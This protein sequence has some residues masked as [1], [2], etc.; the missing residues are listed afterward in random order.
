MHDQPEPRALVD[1]VARFLKQEIAPA[2]RGSAAFQVRIAVNAL[3]LVVRQLSDTGVAEEHARLVALVGRD[4][5]LDELTRLLASGIAAGTFTLATPGL[6]EHLW[7]TTLAKLAVD[8][9]TYQSY[10]RECGAPST[11]TGEAS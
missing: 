11:P 2:L 3:D 10:R 4:G 9:P 7:A 1:A 8:Q 5:T 6:T